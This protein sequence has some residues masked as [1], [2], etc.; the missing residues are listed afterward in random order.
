MDAIL[1]QR[2]VNLLEADLG[3]ELVAL[4]AAGGNCFGFNA[5][6]TAVWRDLLSPKSF[7]EI[8]E[9]LLAQY[10]VDRD[11]CRTELL[12][13]LDDLVEKGLVR[14]IARSAAESIN[15]PHRRPGS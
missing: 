5:V 9:A 1:Y 3:G 4:D 14:K 13:L 10:D 6:A 7:D 2:A 15:V 8:E 12:V 11:Q